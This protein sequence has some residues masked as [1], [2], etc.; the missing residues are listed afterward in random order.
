M[1][2]QQA[3]QDLLELSNSPIPV[4][5]IREKLLAKAIEILE[6]EIENDKPRTRFNQSS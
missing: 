6:K 2:K 5:S 3:L 1:N 4:K